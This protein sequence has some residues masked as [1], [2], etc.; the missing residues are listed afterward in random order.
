MSFLAIYWILL[1]AT[2]TTFS[3]LGSLPVIRQELVLQRHVVTDEQLN[4][5]V[6]IGRTTPGPIG[7]YVVSVGY[8]AAGM[9][10]AAAGWLALVTP[11]LAIPL[12]LRLIGRRADHPR[13]K[14]VMEAI[15]VSSTGLLFAAAIP[16]ARDSL[17]DAIAIGIAILTVALMISKKAD[18]LAIIGG[19]ALIS[20]LAAA[21]HLSGYAVR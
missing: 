14:Q 21:A 5:A 10:G 3:G 19:A 18:S 6:V 20:I 13:T 15:V 9:K 7:L 4:T 17:T 1:K 16:L 12:M 8:Y 11:A 2:V